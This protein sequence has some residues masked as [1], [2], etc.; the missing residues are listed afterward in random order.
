MELNLVD[1]NDRINH[2]KEVIV[3]GLL[4]FCVFS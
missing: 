1:F 4:D 3:F 2:L